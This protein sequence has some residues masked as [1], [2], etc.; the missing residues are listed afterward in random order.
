MAADAGM[1][2]VSRTVVAT[3]LGAVTTD[4]GASP[5]GVASVDGVARRHRG[6][7]SGIRHA[8]IHPA[9]AG[10]SSRRR[11]AISATWSSRI[12]NARGITRLQISAFLSAHVN[13]A[14]TSDS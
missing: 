9:T 8:R 12:A 7:K 11:P 2:S 13:D 4:A 1:A 6:R 14:T 10:K 5:E 3:A